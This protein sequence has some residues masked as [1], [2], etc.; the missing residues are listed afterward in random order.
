MSA[1]GDQT[2]TDLLKL[3]FNATA[4]ANLADNAASSPLTN[5]YVALHT[6]DPGGAGTQSTNEVSYTSY[7]RVAVARSTSG[8]TI[9][10]NF[11]APAA[12]IPFAKP[13][14]AA[15]QLATFASIG[16]L[17]SGAGKIIA[18]L[19]LDPPVPIVTSN[20]P[21]IVRGSKFEID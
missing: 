3:I 18:K 14:G 1:L 13:T 19:A 9:V 6:A 5:L 10:G 4:I 16:Y 21:S 2:I 20:A 11:V 12:D 17:A 15:G 7:A 8:W